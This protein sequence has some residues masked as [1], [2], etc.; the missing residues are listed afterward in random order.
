MRLVIAFL[1]FPLI[2][3]T[4][5]FTD[6]FNP[7]TLR[8]DYFRGGDALTQHLSLDKLIREGEWAGSQ[9]HLTDD[10]RYGEYRI[11]VRDEETGELIFAQGFSTLFMEWQTTAEAK[12]LNRS[13]RESIR[14]PFPIKP[15]S[16]H[17]LTRLKGDTWEEDWK[18]RVDPE[19]PGIIAEPRMPYPVKDIR[20]S[21]EPSNCLDI[22]I[23]AEGYT[24]EDIGKF[25]EDAERFSSYLLKTRP[26]DKMADKISFR[27]VLSTSAESGT[28]LPHLGVWKRTVMNSRFFT[29][30]S[31]RYLT[32]DDYHTMM[33]VAANVP[34]DQVLILVNTDKYGGGGIYNHYLVCTSDNSVSD[35]VFTHEF[36]HSFAGLGD[37]YYSSATAYEDFYD[38]STEPWEPNLTSLKDFD[39]KWKD[40]LDS[41][42]PI[43][44]PATAKFN[45][46]IGVF[47]GGGYVAKG[48]FRPYQQCSMKDIKFDAFC[49][50]CRR[51]ILNMLKQWTE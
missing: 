51:S 28:D 3:F 20:I 1:L 38:L 15:V 44:T 39:H 14:I 42:T 22:A 24:P 34:W 29:F 5:N 41:E 7:Q 32:T 11:E 18:L 23:L 33:D 8:V 40:M 27:A 12:T 47:E 35:Y 46:V 49:P 13:F 19:D 9:T 50:V 21:G 43:P 48:L 36:G 6:Y 31:E 2:S 37:E 4:Q 25:I 30:G 45:E 10:F 16:I 26:Y 17:F